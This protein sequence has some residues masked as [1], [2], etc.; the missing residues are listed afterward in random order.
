VFAYRHALEQAAE[1]AR[2]NLPEKIAARMAAAMVNL[3]PAPTLC[4]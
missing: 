1:A 3:G 4:D 2:Q